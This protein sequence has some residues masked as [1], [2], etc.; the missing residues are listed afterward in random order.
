M[1]DW[2]AR[3]TAGLL[4]AS[5]IALAARRAGMLSTSG[6]CA[7]VV[8]GTVAVAAGWRWGA[9]L[10]V[11]FVVA[12]LLSRAGAG[13]KSR[14]TGGI[15]AKGGARDATQVLATGGICAVGALGSVAGASPAL[16]SL[17]AL[18]AG[19]A[20]AAASA[21]TWATEIGTLLGGAPRALLTG[22]PAPPGT[23]GAVSALGTAAMVAGASFTAAVAHLLGITSAPL[24]VTLAGCIGALMDTVIGATLQER[25]WCD[26]CDRATERP[27]HDCGR[28]T[29]RTAGLAGVDNDVVNLL[30]TLAG[31][32]TAALLAFVL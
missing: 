14:R 21:D 23:S 8:V 19:G 3:A 29:R 28:E 22:R 25:R 7:A 31:A 11:Y 6:A 12:S 4:A 20:L 17:A 1:T 30:A 24:T 9:L 18:A 32:A 2:T 13:E 16:R 10:I 5:C 15:V 26:H 27:V